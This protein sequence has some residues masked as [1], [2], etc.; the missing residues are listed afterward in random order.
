[1]CHYLYSTAQA[2]DI[3]KDSRGIL[4]LAP[5]AYGVAPGRPYPL[6]MDRALKKL[7]TIKDALLTWDTGA[8]SP[9]LLRDGK[10]AEVL[11]ESLAGL[12][13]GCAGWLRSTSVDGRI[14]S[15][16]DGCRL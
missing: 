3:R 4:E 15:D 5:M 13:T 2:R 6:D 10:L 16:H 12:R 8:Q 14:K 7:G 1:M 11:A 9:A